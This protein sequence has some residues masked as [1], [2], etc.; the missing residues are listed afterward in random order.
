LGFIFS[1]FQETKN[2]LKIYA[3]DKNEEAVQNARMN[4][5]ILDIGE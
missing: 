4:A 2:L 1:H 3:F 5:Q